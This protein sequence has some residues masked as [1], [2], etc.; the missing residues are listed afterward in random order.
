LTMGLRYMRTEQIGNPPG[1]KAEQDRLF[2][3]LV[4]AF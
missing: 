1:T 3:D 2:V 4:W